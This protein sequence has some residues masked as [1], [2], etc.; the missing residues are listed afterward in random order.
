[1]IDLNYYAPTNLDEAVQL[2]AGYKGDLKVLA[3]GTDLMPKINYYEN[4]PK[5]VMYVGGLGLDYINSDN[6]GLIIGAGTPIAK[7]LRS[8]AVAKAAPILTEAAEQHSSPAIRSVGTI[9]GNIMNASP[10]ADMVVPLFVLDASL[11]LVSGGGE[12]TVKIGEFFTGPGKTVCAPDEL[13]KEI[14]VPEVRGKTAFIK[15]GKRKAQVLSVISVGVRIEAD[16]AKC[17]EARIALGSVA[18]T[19]IR[20]PEAEALLKGAQITPDLLCKAA[21]AAIGASAPIDDVR[22]TAWYRKEAGTGIARQA[23]FAAAGL[24]YTY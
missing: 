23:L 24:E 21:E 2:M 3:G 22:A 14:R 13:L 6:N 1:M 5:A 11:V 17:N 10:A 18:P 9:G 15:L 19:V 16:G 12:R 20:C 4:T 7:I 8:A